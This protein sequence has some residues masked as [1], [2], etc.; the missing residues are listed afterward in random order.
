MLERLDSIPW[1]TLDHAYGSAEDAP[2]HIRALISD[3]EDEREQAVSGFLWSSA[4]HQWTLYSCTKYVIPF[5]LEILTHRDVTQRSVY[6]STL[7]LELISFI[8]E[9]SFVSDGYEGVDSEIKAGRSIYAVLSN[10]D[11]V[12]VKALALDLINFCEGRERDVS[13]QETASPPSGRPPEQFRWKWDGTTFGVMGLV[14]ACV[15]P[16]LDRFTKYVKDGT[17]VGVGILG[18]SACFAL[19]A[20]SGIAVEEYRLKKQRCKKKS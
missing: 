4:F 18:L 15:M 10:D 17:A 3:N 14:A 19:I 8:F 7:K 5:V 6:E 13:L 12:K 1:H 2:K 11:D 16:L 20:F 9:C